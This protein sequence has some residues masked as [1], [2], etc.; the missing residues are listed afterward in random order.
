MPL[1]KAD[2]GD[3]L[4]L[5]TLSQGERRLALVSIGTALVTGVALELDF[6]VWSGATAVTIAALIVLVVGGGSL[7]IILPRLRALQREAAEQAV[8][9][10]RQPESDSLF[11]VHEHHAH[12]VGNTLSALVAYVDRSERYRSVNTLI[13]SVFGVDHMTI[14]GRTMREVCGDSMYAS[15]SAHIELALRGEIV[16]F[17][18][19]GAA[20]GREY[21]HRSTFA[22]DFGANGEVCG[23]HALTFDITD[24]KRQQMQL[25][26]NE[27]RLRLIADKM[28]ALISYIDADR[29]FRFGN[30]TL[31]HWVDRR[32]EDIVGRR[33]DEVFDEA[34]HASIKPYVDA[35]FRS[36]LPV[37]FDVSLPALEMH[38]QGRFIPDVN[39]AHEIIGIYAMIHDTSLQ[40]NAEAVLKREQLERVLLSVAEHEQERL[41]RELHD[42]VGQ[43]LAGAAFLSK[44]LS[45]RLESSASPLAADAEWIKHLLGRCVESVRS[46]SRQLSPTELERG[47]LHAA[48]D[49]LCV[50]MER[51]YGIEC[52][53][54]ICPASRPI[55]GQMSSRASRQIYRV[56][57]EALN[58]ATRH[59]ASQH[60]RVAA[61]VRGDVMRVA[62][63]D[64]GAGFGGVPPGRDGTAITGVGIR[65]MRLR[66]E[67]L[68]GCLR[69]G[70][71]C[72]RTLVVMRVPHAALSPD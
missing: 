7:G 52:A 25:A 13:G 63:V 48:L 59:G 23:F 70:R 72:G 39:S 37:A 31:A 43:V 44:A 1:T 24:L 57:Q 67:S 30:A 55:C 54:V 28:P 66:A 21:F 19:Y 6:T 16:S 5:R 69:I 58:N 64:D 51:A 45:V 3:T 22:P 68:S 10:H 35:A 15:M 38:F 26:A 46:L 65:S 18:G 41:G 12:G 4:T 27:F 71:H 42:G 14:I 33:I 34:L 53:L 29:R 32:L 50:D 36:V 40:R 8:A 56:I 62:I 17:E 49:R 61:D 2:S 11:R 47:N 9:R 20:D 60:I